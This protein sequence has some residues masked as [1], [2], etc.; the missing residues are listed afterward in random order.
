MNYEGKTE[1]VVLESMPYIDSNM[2]EYNS[3]NVTRHKKV[4]RGTLEEFL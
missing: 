2:T 1:K 4:E 3:K